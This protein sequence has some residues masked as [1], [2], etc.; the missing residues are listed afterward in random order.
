MHNDFGNILLSVQTSSAPTKQT[1]D[2]A[3]RHFICQ[4][5]PSSSSM[6]ETHPL[7]VLVAWIIVNEWGIQGETQNLDHHI[8]FL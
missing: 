8:T 5:L 4:L 1:S 7:Q 2:A 3:A 6:I